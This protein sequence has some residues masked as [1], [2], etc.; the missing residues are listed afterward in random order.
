[1]QSGI[2]CSGR[3]P[4]CHAQGPGF[5]P[6]H[7]TPPKKI[8]MYNIYQYLNNPV[9]TFFFF[10]KKYT[11]DGCLHRESGSGGVGGGEQEGPFS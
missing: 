4:A 8:L 9:E 1:M 7:Y 6:Q 11:L 2:Q 3:E 5:N 10:M